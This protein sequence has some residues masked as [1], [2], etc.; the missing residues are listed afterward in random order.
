MAP[1]SSPTTEGA[2]VQGSHAATHTPERNTQREGR[3]ESME[4]S[5]GSPMSQSTRIPPEYTTNRILYE[6]LQT[7]RAQQNQPQT[8]ISGITSW[9]ER[10]KNMQPPLFDGTPDG[11]MAEIWLIQVEKALDVIQC[12]DDQ[13]VWIAVSNL[14]SDAE[15]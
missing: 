6:L 3:E 5:P 1:S 9:A 12:P 13:R 11:V 7:T 15:H 2:R 14:T 10:F 4:I 8:V